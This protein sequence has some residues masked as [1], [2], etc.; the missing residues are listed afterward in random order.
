MNN[1]D[2]L[3][4][5]NSGKALDFLIDE[6]KHILR[7]DQIAINEPMRNHTTFRIGGPADIMVFPEEELQIVSI[8]EKASEKGIPCTI[9]GN[10]SNILVSD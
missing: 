7:E 8:M 2:I 9:I 6:L 10:G 1:T 3:N 4:K 5:D